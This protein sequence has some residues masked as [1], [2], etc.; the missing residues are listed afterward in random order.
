MLAE[1]GKSVIIYSETNLVLIL[2]E[3]SPKEEDFKEM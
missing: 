1:A 3:K 2:V